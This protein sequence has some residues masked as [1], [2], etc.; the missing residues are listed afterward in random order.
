MEHNKKGAGTQ[1]PGRAKKGE[2]TSGLST[3]SSMNTD[4]SILDIEQ[5]VYS[6]NRSISIPS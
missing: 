1:K 2:G 4:C 3:S 5:P 6:S